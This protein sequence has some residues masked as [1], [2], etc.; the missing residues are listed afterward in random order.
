MLSISRLRRPTYLDSS[1]SPIPS[2]LTR[3]LVMGANKLLRTEIVD[4]SASFMPAVAARIIGSVT[5]PLRALMNCKRDNDVE[6]DPILGLVQGNTYLESVE[7]PSQI[8]SSDAHQC[9]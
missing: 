6:L 2:S 3:F 1:S 5:S 8:T 9:R 4:E 7:T